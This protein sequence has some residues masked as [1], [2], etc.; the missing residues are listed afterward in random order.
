MSGTTP[1]MLKAALGY[2]RLGYAVFPCHPGTKEPATPHGFKDATTDRKRIK[3]W[4]R[5]TPDANVGVNAEGLLVIDIDG[6]DNAWR[7]K[8]W[9]DAPRSRTPRGGT[10]IFYR[11]PE[12]KAW[13]CS[14][15]QLAPKVDVR[16]TGGYVVV[17]PSAVNGKRY[18]SKLPSREELPLPPAWLSKALDALYAERN[19]H[20]KPLVDGEHVR[21]GRRNATLTS[22]AGTMRRR[23]MSKAAIGAALTEENKQI[24]NPPLDGDEVETIAGSVAKYAADKKDKKTQAAELVE[25]ALGQN[26]ELF[27]DRSR[28]AYVSVPVNDHVET[29]R[30]KS[31]SFRLWL[32]GLFYGE[33]QKPPGA[34]AMQDA[35]GILEAKAIFDGE[36]HEVHARLAAHGGKTYL[37]LCNDAWQVIEIDKD[38]YRVVDDPPVHFRRVKA[39]LP[40]PVPEPGSIGLLRRFVNVREEHWCLFLGCLVAAMRPT[41]PY[42]VMLLISEQGSGKSTTSRVMRALVDPNSAPVRAEPREPRDL[43]IAANNAWMI[44]L[45]NVSY[46]PAWLSDA[47]CRTST[48]GGF[49]IRTL[50]ENDEET[51]FDGQRP[52]T[53]NAIEEIGSRSDFLDRAVLIGCPTIPDEMRKTERRFWRQFEKVRPRILGAILKALSTGLRNLPDVK[54]ERSPRM[55]DFCQWVVACAPA[56]KFTAEHFL[57]AY[58][59]NRAT[60]NQTALETSAVIPHLLQLVELGKW[61]GTASELLEKIEEEVPENMKAAKHWPKTARALSGILRRLAPNLRQAGVDVEFPDYPTAGRGRVLTVRKRVGI[62]RSDR[63]TVVGTQKHGTSAATVLR[64]DRSGD[65]SGGNSVKDAANYATTQTTQKPRTLLNG[66]EARLDDT[67]TSNGKPKT[68]EFDR[69]DRSQRSWIE[70]DEEGASVPNTR[71]RR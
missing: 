6:A 44:C 26:L 34:Q 62:H 15:A 66:Q 41:G 32:S 1:N 39:M 14:A 23:G 5:Q 3:R 11:R 37:D 35:L 31:K 52:I 42:P 53:V 18:K 68:E 9:R 55:A 38:G 7:Q 4:W 27:H 57:D 36:E 46:I 50:Y 56:L 16:T 71:R 65:R 63:S 21:E 13:K 29:H 19:G 22:L 8:D 30:I 45:D 33:H 51:I 28:E 43:A 17:A 47:I 49:S 69:S 20:A 60:A 10:H 2:A 40:L 48:G 24:C 58:S 25:L 70:M 54:L 64:S 67:C 59:S 61:E 12:G